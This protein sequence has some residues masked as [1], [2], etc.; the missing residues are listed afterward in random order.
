VHKKNRTSVVFTTYKTQIAQ[1]I[2][3]LCI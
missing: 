2:P 1:L 3:T